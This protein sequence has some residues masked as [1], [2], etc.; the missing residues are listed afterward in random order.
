MKLNLVLGCVYLIPTELNEDLYDI[1]YEK[2]CKKYE[3]S[4]NDKIGY[5][6]EVMDNITIN[7]SVIKNDFVKINVSFNAMVF[8]PTKGSKLKAI[9]QVIFNHGIFCFFEK[10]KILIPVT[11][12]KNYKIVDGELV[13]KDSIIYKTGDEISIKITEYRYEKKQFNCIASLIEN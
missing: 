11:T 5:I 12:L 9:I 13:G 7:D 6:S 4:S 1:V 10:I 2:V 3:K 8:H